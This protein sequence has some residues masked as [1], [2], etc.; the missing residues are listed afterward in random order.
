MFCVHATRPAPSPPSGYRFAAVA[1]ER[2]DGDP[3]FLIKGRAER[4]RERFP[5]PHACYGFTTESGEVV[6]F[7]WLTLARAQAVEVPFRYG[8]NIKIE[9]RQAY[10]WDCATAAEHQNRGLYRTGLAL[11]AA[12]AAAGGASSV[13]I[14]TDLDNHA[15]IRGIEAASGQEL[16]RFSV[17]QSGPLRT[18]GSSAGGVH[19]RLRGQAIG[20]GALTT[21]VARTPL[22]A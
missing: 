9:P 13:F 20:F 14:I 12:E 16:G 10:V 22:R 7:F 11:T 5:S 18:I 3:V 8:L 1:S 19:V 21:A 4:F 6:A 15:S 17:A 2:L